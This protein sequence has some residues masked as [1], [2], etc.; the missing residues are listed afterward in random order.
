MIDTFIE[1]LRSV[2][3]SRVRTANKPNPIEIPVISNIIVIIIIFYI[4]LMSM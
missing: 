1:F 4:K 2:I 3:N